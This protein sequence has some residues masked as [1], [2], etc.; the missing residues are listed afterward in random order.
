MK[1]QL[2]QETGLVAMVLVIIIGVAA[3]IIAYSASIM[4][5]GDL[6][7]AYTS[8]QGNEAL[9]VADGCAEEALYRLKLNTSYDGGN[10]VLANGSCIIVITDHSSPSID[11]L[12]TA[13][14]TVDNY[15][16]K[17]EVDVNLNSGA[18]EIVG[19]RDV[20]L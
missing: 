8:Q 5:L 18:V 2:K 6:E 10:L 14:A 13:A 19:W 4:G 15:N 17:V 9:A 7:M 16:R 3:I 20:S 11:K 1:N 12:V